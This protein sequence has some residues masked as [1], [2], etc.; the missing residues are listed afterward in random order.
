MDDD[1]RLAMA[2]A[3]RL[4]R[5]GRL[6]EATELLQRRLANAPNG[7][8]PRRTAPVGQRAL[9][10]GAP[11]R[12][13]A[14][15]DPS[16]GWPG[17]VG[18]TGVAE[19]MYARVPA[20]RFLDG[21]AS[22][23]RGGLRYKLYLP[24][25]YTGAPLPLV[26]MLHGGTQRTDDFA[27]GTRMNTVADQAAF[28]VAY[29]EQSTS[30]N[31]MR[32]WNWFQ[33]DNQRRGGGEPAVIAGI[34]GDV[35]RDY[36]VDA[37][38]VY[39]AGFSAGGAM[40]AVMAA[41]YP[42][43]Y[44]AAGVHSG[45]A[46]GVAHDVASAFT[47]MKQ[48]PSREVRLPGKAI[49]LIVFHGDR[50]QTVDH[51]NGDR[52]V[53]QWRSAAADGAGGGRTGGAPTVHRAHVPGGRSFTQSTYPDARGDFAMEQWVVHGAGH[54]WSGGGA[55]SSYTDPLGP[56]ASAEMARFFRAHRK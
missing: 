15:A 26:V 31:S 53:D 8:A 45:L 37:G 10:T 48:G 28:L 44:A 22:R 34:T 7:P 56:D 38:Q 1:Q 39:V 51:V 14:K 35:I 18:E 2:E 41:T 42:D 33:A 16:R 11:T 12:T 36:A 3:T 49:P 47:A 27:A 25:G 24:S 46:Y 54:A 50:D 21:S 9:P 4:T 32:Y 20:G 43:V 23:A 19:P 30:A 55:S 29:P 17:G 5:S 13:G 52:L 40:A 6:T